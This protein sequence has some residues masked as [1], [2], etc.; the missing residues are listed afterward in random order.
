LIEAGKLKRASEVRSI[1][2]PDEILPKLCAKAQ[3]VSAAEVAGY[4]PKLQRRLST[5]SKG[6]RRSPGECPYHH[7]CGSACGLA[8]AFVFPLEDELQII[9]EVGR[10]ESALR[11]LKPLLALRCAYRLFGEAKAAHP[12]I[13]LRPVTEI[14]VH[15]KRVYLAQVQVSASEEVVVTLGRQHILDKRAGQ[16]ARIN[17]RA[18]VIQMA[19]SAQKEG[20]ALARQRAAEARVK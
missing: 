10:K 11:E 9:E 12:P 2:H 18:L 17:Y 19:L 7:N 5:R 20:G 15:I 4:V 3:F 6:L 14:I 13:A 16:G 8:D 1:S